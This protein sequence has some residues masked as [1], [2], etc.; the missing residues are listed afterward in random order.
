[1]KRLFHPDSCAKGAGEDYLFSI[2]LCQKGD[3]WLVYGVH[4]RLILMLQEEEHLMSA[5]WV[6]WS[7]QIFPITVCPGANRASCPVGRNRLNGL[8]V[9]C[10]MS[11][12]Y[13][14]LAARTK[15]EEETFEWSRFIVPN[16]AEAFLL[17]G[18]VD[19]WDV[20]SGTGA[21]EVVAAIWALMLFG[22]TV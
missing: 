2:L 22:C 9:I 12:F 20:W 17:V 19:L 11:A 18:A 5:T 3:L 6:S 21:L 8:E 4:C 7:L 1:M 15:A 10:L 14:W 13:L 16:K